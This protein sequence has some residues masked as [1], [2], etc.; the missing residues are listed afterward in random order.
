MSQDAFTVKVMK[1]VKAGIGRN[2]PAIPLH[3]LHGLH[4]LIARPNPASITYYGFT[5]KM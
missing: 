2:F 4:G 5:M 3:V 1:V